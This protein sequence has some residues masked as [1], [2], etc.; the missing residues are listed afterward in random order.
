MA[1]NPAIRF[2]LICKE[3]EEEAS[4]NT[5]IKINELLT[6][7]TAETDLKNLMRSSRS[8]SQWGTQCMSP[9]ISNL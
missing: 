9:F 5:T 2:F 8:Q 6:A 4:M 7:K 1:L 3:T